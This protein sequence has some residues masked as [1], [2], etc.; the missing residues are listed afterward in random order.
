M[1]KYL[2]GYGLT[3]THTIIVAM[4]RFGALVLIV[5]AAVNPFGDGVISGFSGDG[6]GVVGG[7]YV[8]GK[9]LKKRIYRFRS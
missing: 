3:V 6:C 9:S 4:M 2:R 1:V 5:M 8:I 7:G